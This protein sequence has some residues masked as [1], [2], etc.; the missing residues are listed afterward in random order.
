MQ[1]DDPG[2]HNGLPFGRLLITVLLHVGQEFL[3]LSRSAKGLGDSPGPTFWIS[4]SSS[5]R[6]SRGSS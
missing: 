4:V 1:L 5:S 2:L 6:R 3:V